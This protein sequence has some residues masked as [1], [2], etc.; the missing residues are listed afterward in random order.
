MF[1]KG[2]EFLILA[3]SSQANGLPSSSLMV[4]DPYKPEKGVFAAEF[5]I[6][7]E[8]S[9]SVAKPDDSLLYKDTSPIENNYYGELTSD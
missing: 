4:V 7:T 6:P 9:C 5:D 3:L 8:C 2:R 1:G